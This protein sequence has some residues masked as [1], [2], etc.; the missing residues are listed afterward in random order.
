MSDDIA[1]LERRT[2]AAAGE[3]ARLLQGCGETLPQ[4]EH[5][6]A[7][8]AFFDRFGDAR[9]V[10]LGEARGASG[11]VGWP[12][13]GRSPT[14]EIAS[15]DEPLSTGIPRFRWRALINHL[16]VLIIC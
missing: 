10:L 12:A 11:P 1:L 9:V 16:L 4:P 14:S 3:L 5:D 2:Q 7:F 8:G 15:W 6:A 13:T